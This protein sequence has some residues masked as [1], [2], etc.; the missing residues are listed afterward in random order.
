MRRR[1]NKF[2]SSTLFVKYIYLNSNYWFHKQ[3][4]YI[5]IN[6]V[7]RCIVCY[8]KLVEQS[9]LKN[10]LVIKTIYLCVAL[11]NS[12]MCLLDHHIV[13]NS[14]HYMTDSPTRWGKVNEKKKHYVNMPIISETLLKNIV[15]YYV[16]TDKWYGCLILLID[17]L[18]TKNQ[19]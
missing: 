17:R 7:P 6:S 2:F 18:H 19:P 3:A 14:N 4:M 10:F 12:S 1:L 15:L 13:R 5:S 16:I 9:H 11:V 8:S